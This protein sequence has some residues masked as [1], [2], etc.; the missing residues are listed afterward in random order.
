ML[1][2]KSYHHY[3]LFQVELQ[4]RDMDVDL[5]FDYIYLIDGDIPISPIAFQDL[6]GSLAFIEANII[7]PSNVLTLVFE[8]DDFGE[9]RGAAADVYFI[10]KYILP[11]GYNHNCKM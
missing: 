9:F 5:D 7:A 4:I 10:G 1:I 8:S 2:E 6:T 11:T 3:I